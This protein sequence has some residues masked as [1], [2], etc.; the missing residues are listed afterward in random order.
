M[1]LFLS[2]FSITVLCVLSA[3]L[4]SFG[5]MYAVAAVLYDQLYAVAFNQSQLL[6]LSPP[7]SVGFSDWSV[8]IL[9]LSCHYALAGPAEAIFHWTG[10]SLIFIFIA[11]DH[12]HSQFV[13]CLVACGR[14]SLS[15]KRVYTDS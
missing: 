6:L 5:T 3:Q 14:A 10:N 2:V 12:A 7:Q 13:Q 11:L 1:L 9:V 15:T 4:I 8:T